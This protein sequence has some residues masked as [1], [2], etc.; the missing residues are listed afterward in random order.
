MDQEIIEQNSDEVTRLAK[1]IG[2]AICKLRKERGYS[3]EKLSELSE[4]DVVTISRM[5]NG[6]FVNVNTRNISKIAAALDINDEYFYVSNASS[7]VISS[8]LN[9]LIK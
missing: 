4:I 7:D 9:L 6:K 5:E 3:Q 2:K 8:T 1:L